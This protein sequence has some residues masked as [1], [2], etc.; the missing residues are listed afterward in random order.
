M[1]QPFHHS[2]VQISQGQMFWREVGH[3]GAAIIF[4]HGSWNDS[5]QWVPLMQ[6][7][8]FDHH[9]FAP[10]LLGCSESIA[11][12]KIHPSVSL[13]VD[14]LADYINTL[15]LQHVCLVGHGLGAWI[16]TS[17]ALKYPETVKGLVVIAPE[18]I[19]CDGYKQHWGWL[20]GLLSSPSLTAGFLK[21]ISP[22]G[23]LFG[24]G[25]KIRYWLK[26]RQEMLKWN[27]ATKLLYQRRWRE[28]QAEMLNDRLTWLKLPTLILQGNQDQAIATAQS[29]T[30]QSIAPMAQLQMIDGGGNNLPLQM[31]EVLA[32]YLREFV[33]VHVPYELPP[34]PERL[35]GDQPQDA[36]QDQEVWY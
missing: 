26:G 36:Y 18:G 20:R 19:E 24:Q 27:L 35:D 32:Q 4:L 6:H 17:Y 5:S 22:F 14:C 23:F 31:P 29:H 16:A 25:K 33:S 30:Y 12:T 15:K 13:E 10:D 3:Q 11:S 2:R 21:L 1:Y 8:S 28:V 34:S 9:C 7:L